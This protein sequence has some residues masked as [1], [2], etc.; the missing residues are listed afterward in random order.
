MNALLIV[1]ACNVD[2]FAAGISY[3]CNKIRIPKL[4]ILIIVLIST[5]FIACSLIFGIM[6]NQLITPK[7]AIAIGSTILITIGLSKIFTFIFKYIVKKRQGIKG[8]ISF[9]L[10]SLKFIISVCGTPEVADID[11]NKNLSKLEA[12]FLAVALSIDNLTIGI[13]AGIVNLTLLMFTIIVIFNLICIVIMIYAGLTIGSKLA[14]KTTLN[15]S[16]L[17]GMLLIAIALLNIFN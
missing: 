16:W 11:N 8:Q 6:L 5:F 2:C 7:I 13:G 15:L 14:K 12:I 1:L 4:S 3:G 17:S 9:N 10:F